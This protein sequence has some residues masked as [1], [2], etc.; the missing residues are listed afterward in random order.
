DLGVLLASGLIV[1][2]STIG[3]VLSAIVVFS[4]V[5]A[6]LALVSPHFELAARIIGGVA[7]VAIAF[8]LYRWIL[9]MAAKRTA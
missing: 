8:L 3:V 6:P 5:A 9:Q 2:E 7:F 4:G 1:G